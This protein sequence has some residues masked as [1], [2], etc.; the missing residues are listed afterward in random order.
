MTKPKVIAVV[1]PTASGKTS[2]SIEIAKQYKGEVIS[3]DSRQVYRGMDLGT[4]K[5]T[6]DEMD[7]VPHHLLDVADPTSVYTAADFERDATAATTDILSRNHLPIFAGGTF[8]YL[9]ILRGKMSPA[10]V[11]PNPTLRQQ[12]EQ[13]T[14]AELLTKLQTSDPTRAANIDPHNR[15]R[16]IR[17]LEIIDALG[18]VPEPQPTES[19][20]DW[21]II[22]INIDPEALRQN[23][24]VRLQQRF[25]AGMVEE[26]AH[27][28]DNGLSYE[29]MEELGLEYRYI[30]RYLQG[31]LSYEE[32]CTTLETKIAQFAKRQR[33]WL[34][35]DT[36]I[37]WFKKDD[38]TA[39]FDAIHHF[40]ES[41]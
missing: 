11:E 30:G 18:A 24:H 29:R 26:V 13:S 19:I 15:R 17:S 28:H 14:D 4:G 5:V 16:L 10:P 36:A 3:A 33:T 34:R 7:G 23:I 37:Q 25:D 9:D 27:L 2:L 32:M 1:G 20:Y 6:A 39:I 22:G 12:L 31:E 35:R 21:L 40:L 41:A 38:Q 8:F